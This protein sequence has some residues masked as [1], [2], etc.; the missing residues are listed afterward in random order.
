MIIFNHCLQLGKQ[1]VKKH[2]VVLTTSKI[3]NNY[4]QKKKDKIMKPSE[5]KNKKA[6]SKHLNL[7]I[8]PDKIS[9]F[10]STYS[11]ATDSQGEPAKI[12]NTVLNVVPQFN[13]KRRQNFRDSAPLYED[14]EIKT[15]E[16]KDELD[17]NKIN[18]DFSKLATTARELNNKEGKPTGLFLVPFSTAPG[19]YCWVLLSKVSLTRQLQSAK[20]EKITSK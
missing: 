17:I 16:R 7:D 12:L 20:G 5:L 13:T 15:G 14:Y 19:S 18:S 3:N 11:I 1:K 2:K 10:N 8:T 6:G 4:L 9:V